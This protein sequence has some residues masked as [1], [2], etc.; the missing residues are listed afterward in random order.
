[1]TTPDN[2]PSASSM[3]PAM[4][5]PKP[6]HSIRSGQASATPGP[7]AAVAPAATPAPAQQDA[8]INQPMTLTPETAPAPQQSA[9]QQ[10]I[11]APNVS[12]QTVQP[13]PEVANNDASSGVMLPS[14]TQP[15]LTP[16]AGTAVTP[17]P[18]DTTS[19]AAPLPVLAQ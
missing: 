6:V 18:A 3:A 2:A 5:A 19:P 9:M 7:A 17:A 4:S 10:P 8:A 16:P 15:N 13:T 11:T 12:G 1:M 14:G